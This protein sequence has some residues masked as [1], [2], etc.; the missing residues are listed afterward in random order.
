[1]SIFCLTCPSVYI[2]L[3]LYDPCDE[4]VHLFSMLSNEKFVA[5]VVN[6]LCCIGN[7]DLRGEPPHMDI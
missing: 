3:N 1:M 2:L 5:Y 6:D 4:L 7:T